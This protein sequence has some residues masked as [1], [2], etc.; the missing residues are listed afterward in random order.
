MRH[1]PAPKPWFEAVERGDR[2]AVIDMLDRGMEIDAR[3]K[4]STT[5]LIAAIRKRQARIVRILLDCG[6]SLEPEDD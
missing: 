4:I 5:A 3:G 1:D 6:A 2:E